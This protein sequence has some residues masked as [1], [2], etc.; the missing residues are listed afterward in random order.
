MA[1]TYSSRGMPKTNTTT[2]TPSTTSLRPH[3]YHY[4][5]WVVQSFFHTW[6]FRCHSSTTFSQESQ[7]R[8]TNSCR[9][10]PAFRECTVKRCI[11]DVVWCTS[12]HRPAFVWPS[13]ELH[14]LRVSWTTRD[15]SF[16]R[17]LC[18][19]RNH[20]CSKACYRQYHTQDTNQCWASILYWC[21]LLILPSNL[22]YW[23]RCFFIPRS[24]W[25]FHCNI[26]CQIAALRTIHRMC[27]VLG[28]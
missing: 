1:D 2:T 25:I 11:V 19:C 17:Q 5:Y 15:I 24:W 28:R 16:L 3:H 14:A 4:H 26:A 21:C 8:A 13:G 20:R 27:W 10:I 23:S 22:D 12:A 6:I 18:Q 9:F 7:I